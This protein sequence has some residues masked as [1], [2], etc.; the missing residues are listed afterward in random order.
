MLTSGIRKSLK[1]QMGKS[2][3]FSRSPS[4]D[5][6]LGSTWAVSL[7]TVNLRPNDE[8][9]VPFIWGLEPKHGKYS[10]GP[11]HFVHVWQ[12]G[13]HIVI[14]GRET[15]TAPPGAMRLSLTRVGTKSTDLL[16]EITNL[17][18]ALPPL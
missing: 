9:A 3:A 17:G 14:N 1:P 13:L 11:H 7:T 4:P 8:L 15:I 5:L 16:P 10:S 2:Q 6:R 18:T 12:I